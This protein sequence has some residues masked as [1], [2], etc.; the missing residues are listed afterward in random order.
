MSF[1]EAMDLCNLPIV[2]FYMDEKK[3][4]FILDTGADTNVIDCNAIKGMKVPIVAKTQIMGMEGNYTD[5]I[6]TRLTLKY[7][8]GNYTDDFIVHDMSAAFGN[9]KK[10]SGVNVHGIV[11]SH[12]FRKYEYMLDFQKLIAYSKSKLI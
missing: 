6:K 4:N 3:F 7:K 1:R 8:E 11:S 12:F 5:V 9:I 10:E 2:T